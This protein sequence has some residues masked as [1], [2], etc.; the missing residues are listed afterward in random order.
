MESK[1]N[2]SSIESYSNAYTKKVASEFYKEH[3]E[4]KGK[5]IINLCKVK[6]INLLV[7]KNLFQKWKK[8]T[9]KLQSPYFNYD[10]KEVVSALNSFMNVL[11]Q[12]ISI[13]RPHFEPLLKRAVYDTILLVFSPY[14][15]YS[16]EIN[17][18]EKTRVSLDE[19]KE[20]SNYV[21]INSNLLDALIARFVNDD[22]EEVFNDEGFSLL[23]EIFEENKIKPEDYKEY[24]EKFSETIPLSLDMIF[25]EAESENVDE[26]FNFLKSKKELKEEPLKNLNANFFKEHLTLN[27]K[28]NTNTKPT[29]ADILQK[30]KIDNIKKNISINQRFM[31]INELFDGK[32]DEFNKAVDEL[33]VCTDYDE[34]LKLLNNKYHKKYK[35]E[36]ESEEVNEFLGIVAKK[37]I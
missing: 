1:L 19:L 15:F 20:L 2:H 37:F 18:P 10:D 4:I 14:D 9:E 24:L 33:E 34:A 16:K 21:K 8:E 11:S 29:L 32:V 3:E 36:K 27:E 35:W 28:F 22:V 17:N 7:I 31:F 30:K 6:Q 12:N 26:D 13:K 25:M 5:E 23:N